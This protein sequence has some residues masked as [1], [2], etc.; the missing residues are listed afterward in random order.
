MD[1][2]VFPFSQRKWRV[3]VVGLLPHLREHSSV[4]VYFLVFT[5]SGHIVPIILLCKLLVSQREIYGITYVEQSHISLSAAFNHSRFSPFSLFCSFCT[6]L[7]YFQVATILLL[8]TIIKYC[9]HSTK[10]TLSMLQ[11]E[12]LH[13]RLDMLMVRFSLGHLRIVVAPAVL[14]LRYKAHEEST[15]RN[16]HIDSRTG[17]K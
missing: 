2:S 5:S 3:F 9:G 16:T 12:L 11:F 4:V 6:S 13:D 15:Q 10:S 7:G 1:L 17:S 14:F 8:H